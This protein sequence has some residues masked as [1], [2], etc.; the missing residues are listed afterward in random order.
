MATLLIFITLLTGTC[1]STIIREQVFALRLEQWLRERA[2]VLLVYCIFFGVFYTAVREDLPFEKS[3]VPDVGVTELVYEKDG[4]IFQ[5]RMCGVHSSAF[6]IC[7]D[8]EWNC[9]AFCTKRS[10]IKCHPVLT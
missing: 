5:T 4:L 8:A 1:T 6:F 9:L 3:G 2:I 10:N 7:A